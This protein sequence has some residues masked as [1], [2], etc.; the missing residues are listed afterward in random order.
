MYEIFKERLK[1]NISKKEELVKLV[2]SHEPLYAESKTILSD[3]NNQLDSLRARLTG[4]KARVKW[5]KEQNNI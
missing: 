4:F 2:E 3:Q 1:A 5:F